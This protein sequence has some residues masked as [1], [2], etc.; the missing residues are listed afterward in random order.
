[1]I[2]DKDIEKL[3]S[4]IND[5]EVLVKS[6]K[7]DVGFKIAHHIEVKP[8]KGLDSDKFSLIIGSNSYS[9]DKDSLL[10]LLSELQREIQNQEKNEKKKD[11]EFIGDG[12]YKVNQD[13]IDDMLYSRDIASG[14]SSYSE[15]LLTILRLLNAKNEL[16]VGDLL[17]KNKEDFVEKIMK[18]QYG[19]TSLESELK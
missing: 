8:D 14:R 4:A 1:M 15:K 7:N 9:L 5:W 3:L 13:F 19:F 16:I 11:I 6:I 10:S 17:I 12:R 2:P 18:N